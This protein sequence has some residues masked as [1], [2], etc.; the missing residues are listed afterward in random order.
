M[1]AVVVVVWVLLAAIASAS[2]APMAAVAD[3]R[4]IGRLP[5]VWAATAVAIGVL[6]GPLFLPLLWCLG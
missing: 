2:I 6:L 1:H 4:L 3:V 5:Q